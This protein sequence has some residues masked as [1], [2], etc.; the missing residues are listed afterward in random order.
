[1][2]DIGF[3]PTE[4]SPMLVA[5]DGREQSDG[6][7]RAGTLLARGEKSWR[8]ITVA[9]P[10]PVMAPELDL[11]LAAEA[12]ATQREVQLQSA[13]QQVHRILGPGKAVRLDVHEGYPAD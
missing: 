12:V 11:R 8:V 2:K 9:P 6:A 1:M 5:I 4:S 10:L 3:T 7:I 13:Q